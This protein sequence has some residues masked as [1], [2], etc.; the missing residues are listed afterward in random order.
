M[1]TA[2]DVTGQTSGC[3][4]WCRW[5]DGHATTHGH[6]IWV[7]DLRSKEPTGFPKTSEADWQPEGKAL[8]C[9]GMASQGQDARLS[10]DCSSE[11]CKGLDGCPLHEKAAGN[12]GLQILTVNCSSSYPY[13]TF[14]TQ[15]GSKHVTGSESTITRVEGKRASLNC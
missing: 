8:Q 7:L 15:Q 6:D 11:R 3:E 4:G 10:E 1:C 5:P 14:M 9:P 12:A 13:P 2:G